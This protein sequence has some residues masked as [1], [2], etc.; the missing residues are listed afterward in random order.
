MPRVSAQATLGVVLVARC[1]LEGVLFAS[2]V[3]A[4]QIGLAGDRAV[5]TVAVALALTGVG[6]I[7]A[8]ILRDARADRQN[9]AIALT[10]IGAAAL[11]G[12]LLKTPNADGLQVLTRLVLFGIL[13]EA[14]VWRNLSVARGLVRWVDARNSAFAAVGLVALVAL[15]P[16]ALD[17]TGLV[18]AGLAATAAAGVALSLTRSAE[19]LA[20]SGAEARG[21]ASRTT[22]SGAAIV[23][24]IVSVIGAVLAPS[25]G[26]L[27][28]QAGGAIAP[29]VGGLLYGILLIFGY[30]AAFLVEVFRDFLS[31]GVFPRIRPPAP[32]LTPQEEAEAIRQIEAAR[33]FV[34]GTVELI[35]AAIAVLL[36]VI[37]VDR[38]ARERRASL[39]DGTTLDRE[40]EPG[41]GIAA[42]LA[43][44]LPRRTHR[45]RPPRD[46]GTPAGALRALYW[47]YL[48]RSEAAGV[49][50][51]AVGET[52]AE[53]QDRA[54]A[55]GPRFAAAATLVRAFEALRYGDHDPDGPTLDAARA[56]VAAIEAPR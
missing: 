10:A 17:R 5:P 4:A 7:L 28:G 56:A 11:F 43:G 32:P 19:E 35:F 46:D 39:P 49:A 3:S 26:A 53:H 52:P 41:D 40:S 9:T 25:V 16:G 13:G 37:L 30:A 21:A 31:R 44:L 20:L 50:W 14:F 24:A 36:V 1:V 55:G 33:P 34:I 6:V 51:R 47:R 42:F 18:V 29:I 15:L 23:L 54:Q 27:V 45:P 8:S 12:L 38:M 48:A 2:L 22:A